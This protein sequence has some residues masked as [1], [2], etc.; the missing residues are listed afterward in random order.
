[1]NVSKFSE[2]EIDKIINLYNSGLLQKE[3]ASI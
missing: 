2:K 1:M 3:I